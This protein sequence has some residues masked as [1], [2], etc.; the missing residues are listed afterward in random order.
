MRDINKYIDQ[1]L[2]KPDATKVDIVNF[3]ND[4][5]QH[6]FYALVVNSCWV[7]LVRERLSKAT[8]LCSVV[9]FPLGASNTQTKVFAAEELVKQGVHEIDMV[10]NIGRL[11]DKDFKYVGKE[12]KAVAAACQ[13]RILKVIIETCMLDD[14]QKKA[15]A[16]IIR[17]SGAHFVK[18]STG[19]SRAGAKIEDV[20]LLREAVGPDFGVKASGGIRNYR[21]AVEFVNAGANRLGTSSGIQIMKE[22]GRAGTDDL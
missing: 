10:L 17:E 16:N 3:L 11:K 13:G 2:L 20:R 9:D 12:I 8:R 14:E 18:T 5:L 6:G 1:T 15:A 22:A 19:F 7:P 21:Q 4:A